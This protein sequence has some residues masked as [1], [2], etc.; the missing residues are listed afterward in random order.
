M[1]LPAALAAWDT[2]AF[3]DTLKREVAASAGD[4]ALQRI[5]HLSLNGSNAVA[6][7]PLTVLVLDSEADPVAIRIKL[8]MFFAGLHA[9][10]S[11]AGDPTSV[12]VQPEYGEWRLTIDRATAQVGFAPPDA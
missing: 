4:P 2:P 10:C 3:V 6:D 1:Q 11:C 5:L 7:E 12:D 8:G 9:G